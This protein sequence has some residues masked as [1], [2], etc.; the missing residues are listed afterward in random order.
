MRK[1]RLCLACG[2]ASVDTRRCEGCARTYGARLCLACSAASGRRARFCGQCGARALTDPCPFLDLSWLPPVAATAALMAAAGIAARAL[3][4]IGRQIAGPFAA[5]ALRM[6]CV[7]AWAVAAIVQLFFVFLLVRQ[8]LPVE[9]TSH[10]AQAFLKPLAT[11]T[12][13]AGRFL[14]AA[15]RTSFRFLIGGPR[16]KP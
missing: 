2:H 11:M 1:I 12:A 5:W 3:A 16:P 7:A 15:V 6:Q 14:T 10:V 9:N 8:L 13:A 4:G